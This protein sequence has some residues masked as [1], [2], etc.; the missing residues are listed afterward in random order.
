M[1]NIKYLTLILSVAF[2]LQ[3]CNQDLEENEAIF[4]ESVGGL[5]SINTTT[6]AYVVGNDAT[7]TSS[8]SV[9]QGRVTVP[10]ID[11]MVSFTSS[12]TGAV[13][14]QAL[15]TT[16]TPAQEQN[17]TAP[18]E[19]SFKYEDLIA[20]LTI[21]GV[22]LSTNDGDLNI[23]DSFRLTYLP[24]TSTGGTVQNSAFSN[25]SVGTRFA[26][27][28]IPLDGAYYRIGVFSGELADWP[29][30]IVIESVDATTYRV[31]EYF[32]FFDGN[33][34]FFQIDEN[35]VITY[36]P[37]TPA[38]DGQTGN[39]QPLIT[40]QTNPGDMTNVPCDPSL[41]NYVQRDDITGADILYMTMGYFTGGS[42]SREFYQV[43]QK[44]VD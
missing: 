25:V 4:V 32:G 28:Y 24:S 22:P 31:V 14:N 30:E 15:L 3:S 21:D 37:E 26:G 42:G 1:K 36:P 18:F 33:E 12:A 35:D 5:L 10:S 27:T 39:G 43:L 41:T 11:V 34:W 40:C 9:Y 19:F 2:V 23:G 20:G 29:D 13:S 6:I 44:D 7:Y 8:G 16:L 17:K 38:G